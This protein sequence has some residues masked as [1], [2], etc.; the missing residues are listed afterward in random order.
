MLAHIYN[1]NA[2]LGE[3]RIHNYFLFYMESICG[4][5]L[6]I[7]LS[8]FICEYLKNNNI[9]KNI[10]FFFKYISLNAL[11]ILGTHVDINI[12]VDQSL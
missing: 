9:F 7:A 12:V 5:I 11:P 10:L 3:N 1:P 4:R 2:V 6:L 8:N